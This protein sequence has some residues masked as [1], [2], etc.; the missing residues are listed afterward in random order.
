MPK[1]RFNHASA[2]FFDNAIVI[3]GGK[4]EKKSNN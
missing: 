1:G 3:F 2:N 4:S